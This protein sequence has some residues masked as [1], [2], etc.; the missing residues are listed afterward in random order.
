MIRHYLI[1]TVRKLRA[2]PVAWFANVA[3]LAI[4]L[5]CF[6]ASYGAMVFFVSGDVQHMRAGRVAV[7]AQRF[8]RPGGE[9][10]NATPLL[11]SETL[12]R[13]LKQDLP[14]VG[15]IARAVGV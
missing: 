15:T 1:V 13:Y 11:S 8:D 10:T 6:L 4:G 7:I 2:H 12:S 14:N 5:T 9:V 3:T